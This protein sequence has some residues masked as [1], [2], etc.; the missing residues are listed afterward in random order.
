MNEEQF[1][2]LHDEVKSINQNTATFGVKM[3]SGEDSN[4]ELTYSEVLIKGISCALFGKK[5]NDVDNFKSLFNPDTSLYKIVSD[6]KD[7]I[8]KIVSNEPSNNVKSSTE[9]FSKLIQSFK[10]DLKKSPIPVI[11]SNQSSD[12]IKKLNIENISLDKTTVDDITSTLRSEI[13]KNLDDLSLDINLNKKSKEKLESYFNLL[14]EN[15]NT[16]FTE[17]YEQIISDSV[18]NIN[19]TL[20]DADFDLSNFSEK[21]KNELNKIITDTL[22]VSISLSPESLSNF[23]EKLKNIDFGNLSSSINNANNILSGLLAKLDDIDSKKYIFEIDI[24]GSIENLEKININNIDKLLDQLKENQPLYKL[25]DKI[26]SLKVDGNNLSN[27]NIISNFISSILSALS[28]KKINVKGVETISAL[29]ESDGAFTKLLNN[30]KNSPYTDEINKNVI[31]NI[32]NSESLFD[33]LLKL[34]ELKYSGV[35]KSEKTLDYINKDYFNKIKKVIENINNLNEYANKVYIV[36]KIDALENIIDIIP[37]IASVSIFDMLWSRISIKYL[38]DYMTNDIPR[39]FKTLEKT[40]SKYKDS[41]K[42]IEQLSICIDSI[43]KIFELDQ[44]KLIDSSENIDMISDIMSGELKDLFEKISENYNEQN[45]EKILANIE[46]IHGILEMLDFND[47]LPSIMSLIKTSIKLSLIQEETNIVNDILNPKKY[48]YIN[49]KRENKTDEIIENLKQFKKVLEILEDVNRSLENITIK[50]VI[51]V[52][53]SVRLELIAIDNVFKKLQ[54]IDEEYTT[55][56][57]FEGI[58]NTINNFNSSLDLLKKSYNEEISKISGISSLIDSFLMLL[59]EIDTEGLSDKSETIGDFIVNSMSEILKK[60]KKDSDLDVSIRAMMQVEAK[61]LENIENIEKIITK[62]VLMSSSKLLSKISETG[63]AAL[64]KAADKL[65]N[66]VNKLKDI[67]KEDLEGANKT[68]TMLMKVIVGSAAILLFGS[69]MMYYINPLNLLMFALALGGFITG[70]LFVYSKLS[71]DT[72]ESSFDAA[73]DLALLIAISGATL[74]FGSLLFHFINLEDLLGYTIV[75][76][77]FISAIIY[78]YKSFNKDIKKTFTAAYDLAILIAVSGA[79]LI[80]GSLLFH[81]INWKDLVGFTIALGSFMFVMLGLYALFNK[82]FM[83]ALRG[84]KDF[85]ILIGVSAGLLILGALIGTWIWENWKPIAK[86]GISLAIFVGVFGLIWCGFSLIFKSALK[87]AKEFSILIL[88]SAAVMI[89]GPLIIN[90]LG[91]HL[92]EEP[93]WAIFK[94]AGTLALF[95]IGVG[96]ALWIASLGGKKSLMAAIGLS[97]VVGVCAFALIYGPLYMK[98]NGVDFDK[99][100]IP[101]AIGLLVFTVLM[102]GVIALLGQMD[103]S[104]LIKGTLCVIV[105]GLITLGAAYVMTEFYNSIKNVSFEVLLKGIA[106]MGLVFGAFTALIAGLGVLVTG[107]QAI[108][109]GAGAAALGVLEGLVWGAAKVM[110]AIAIALVSLKRASD[111]LQFKNGK[112]EAVQAIMESINAFGNMLTLLCDK[113]SVKN[114]AKL[115][116]IMPGIMLGVASLSMIANIIKS[117]AN[118]IVPDINKAGKVVGYRKLSDEEIG[119][120]AENIGTVLKAIGNAVKDVIQDPNNKDIFGEGFLS[121]KS[122]FE[123]AMKSFKYSGDV[124]SGIAKGIKDWSSMAIPTGFDENGKPKGYTSLN[125]KELTHVQDNIEKV[126]IALGTAIGTTVRK[127]PEMFIGG[128]NSQAVTASKA[129]QNTSKS[130]TDIVAII[131]KFASKDFEAILNK[132]DNEDVQHPGIIQNIIKILNGIVNILDLFLKPVPG[133]GVFWDD[134]FAEHLNKNAPELKKAKDTIAEFGNTLIAIFGT[135]SSIG[136]S[137]MSYEQYIKYMSDKE[138]ASIIYGA[139]LN[140]EVLY[141]KLLI[142]KRLINKDRFNI[143]YMLESFD[144]FSKTL[145]IFIESLQKFDENLNKNLLLLTTGIFNLYFV[146]SH[147]K[148]HDVFEQYVKDIKDFVE[149]VEGID[150]SKFN[151]MTSL[152]Q[153]LNELSGKVGNLD[154]F[155]DGLSEKLTAVLYELVTQLRKAEAT[156]NNAHELQNRRKILIDN[157]INKVKDIMSQHMVVEVLK[158]DETINNPSLGGG[159]GNYSGGNNGTPTDNNKEDS[160]ESPENASP[161][162][163]KDDAESVK[164]KSGWGADALTKESFV[165]IMNRNFK[166]WMDGQNGNS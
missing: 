36:D 24:E 157:S 68:L 41:Y 91:S 103:W 108:V 51:K 31:K 116:L 76:G 84:A 92:G 159:G 88:V 131:E 55:E 78:V 166:K 2:S 48:P 38:N 93:Y 114:S 40:L 35:K 122:P 26:K 96:V 50:S 165:D 85:A 139:L 154:E 158:G 44:T 34:V 104:T 106:K 118:L 123:V 46:N 28:I 81:F 155:V 47:A 80:F 63:L 72:L 98:E 66:V 126:L 45:L 8:E 52:L 30:I 17:I 75:L 27:L 43:L 119:K 4:K 83:N 10:D 54:S 6:I 153:A 82:W 9:N 23:E 25:I 22:N 60:F 141:E 59:N 137:Y 19:K 86:F 142:I 162:Q 13:E 95:V 124:L 100:V 127:Y 37:K 32:E 53:S 58:K 110:N 105:I 5:L 7:S 145:I 29:V 109:L 147:I 39:I 1:K 62:L 164:A 134:S 107:P 87:G 15:V 143:D 152:I 129:I 161:L 148:E 146:T 130:L 144:K 21:L 16:N 20:K 135:L 73:Y 42:D 99:D 163:H 71:K 65:Y 64:E 132:L 90:E 14:K 79:T 133:T 117:W 11:I 128:Q 138:K 12:S 111:V 121:G 3:P 125:D 49:F 89:L 102:G 33:A 57:K 69:I 151:A 67:K 156:I 70:V 101:F 136:E 77:A 61:D 150:L 115:T 97:V 74:I 112:S 140:I 18:N 94:F 149:S 120:A 113:I 160:L 56:I